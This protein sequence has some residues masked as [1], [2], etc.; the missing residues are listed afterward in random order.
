MCAHSNTNTNQ[1]IKT[2]EHMSAHYIYTHAHTHAHRLLT[3]IVT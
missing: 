3:N 1:H 2:L